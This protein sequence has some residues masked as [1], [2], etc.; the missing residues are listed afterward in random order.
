L[1]S[2]Q[3]SFR[4]ADIVVLKGSQ[5]L[6]VLSLLTLLSPRLADADL[7]F[8]N[9]AGQPFGGALYTAGGPCEIASCFAIA[10]NFVS[11]EP[12]TVTGFTFYLVTQQDSAFVASNARIAVF[13]A[14]G[15]EVLAPANVAPTVT[16][17][18]LVVFD[19][20]IIYK[21][22]VT[23]LAI[24][25]PEGEYQFRY[26]NIAHQ[27]IAPGYGNPSAQT[28]SPGMQQLTGSPS[29]ESLIS[30]EVTQRDENWAFQVIGTDDTTFEDG[31]ETPP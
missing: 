8:S 16:D 29:V 9:L 28:I 11:D 3:R 17:T 1:F 24:E 22:D 21:L 5:P 12:W 30:T 7:L 19:T 4:Q 27:N 13:T 25:L 31:F 2:G 10:D 15:A 6:V 26:T 23:G 20:Y 18:G 14:A